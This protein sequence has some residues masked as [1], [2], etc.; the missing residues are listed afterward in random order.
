[1]PQR[2]K[3]KWVP[4]HELPGKV[5]ADM[6]MEVLKSR[7]IP[8]Y[9]RSL[10]GSGAVGVVSGTDL[11]GSRDL[12]MVPEEKFEEAQGVLHDMFDHI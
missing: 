10:Y 3:V 11:V 8:C 5:Y 7:G 1:M 12:I 2:D 9:L 6:V 4:L